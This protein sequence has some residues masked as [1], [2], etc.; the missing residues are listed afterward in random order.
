MELSKKDLTKIFG[1]ITF[2]LSKSLK[3]IPKIIG[4][5]ENIPCQLFKF[6]S[7]KLT[8]IIFCLYLD[9][10]DYESVNISCY[11]NNNEDVKPEF[12]LGYDLEQRTSQIIL[13][14][15]TFSFNSKDLI[16]CDDEGIEHLTNTEEYSYII[17]SIKSI[18]KNNRMFNLLLESIH[19]TSDIDILLD[20][21]KLKKLKIRKIK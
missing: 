10:I 16:C 20:L 15:S 9:G 17:K 2:E 5:Y 18:I 3:L 11:L 21:T 13:F 4:V 8:N 19:F 14:N 7:S 12:L 1:N 6:S